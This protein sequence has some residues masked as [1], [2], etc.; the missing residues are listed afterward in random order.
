MTYLTKDELRRLFQVA[1]DRNRLHHLFLVVASWHG[2]RV[3][4]A[5]NVEGIDIADGQ[6]N[7]NRLKKSNDSLQPLHVDVD[8]LLDESPLIE[9]AAKNPGRLFP[10]S[11]QRADQFIKRYAELSGIHP[12]KAHM[13]SL[14]HSMAMLLWDKTH[15]L[16]QIQSYLGHK[17]PSSTLQYL[18]EIDARKAQQAVAGISI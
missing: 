10:F 5:I 16:G 2:L 6:L 11:R 17:S 12:D 18:V 1:Y 15:N 7:I 8:P 14:K 9:M 4:E 3:S 13:H